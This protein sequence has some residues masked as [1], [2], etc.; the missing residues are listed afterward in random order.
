MLQCR[1]YLW[2]CGG[3]DVTSTAT[4]VDRTGWVRAEF[5]ACHRLAYL[6]VAA[7]ALMAERVHRALLDH[8]DLCR[9]EGARKEEWIARVETVRRRMA[10]F[11]HAGP[12]EIAFLK[13]TSDGVNTVAASLRLGDGDNVI[14]CPEFEHANNVYPWLHLRD[15]GVETR[16]VPLRD[17]QIDPV[18]VRSR[19]NRRTRVVS[20]SVVSAIT[21]ARAPVA[22]LAEMCRDRGVFLF[23][24]AAQSLG[25]VETD[26]GALG[27][28]GLAGATQKGMLGMYGLGILYVR[29]DWLPRLRPPSLSVTGVVRDD[30]HES[31]RV[32]DAGYELRADARR[33]EIGNPNFAG[34]V[35][36]DAAL[37][38]LEEIRPRQVEA[39]VSRLASTLIERLRDRGLPVRTP[40]PVSR[41]AGIVAFEAPEPVRLVQHLRDNDVRVSLRR[42][43]VR[44][45]LHAYND[46]SDISRLMAYIP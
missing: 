36:L 13:N 35:A 24:D 29:S 17:G 32:T 37:S 8:L 42:G 9:A 39:H 30:R 26:V 44:A 41:R 3:V 12:D 33:F 45:S 1:F 28:D 43:L 2:F 4:A 10:A 46:E 7:R 21:G 22:V 20:V 25:V 38:L 5:A 11:I 34:V 18:E 19:M 6:D 40:L 16:L 14:V 15:S 23:A 27:V 31:D